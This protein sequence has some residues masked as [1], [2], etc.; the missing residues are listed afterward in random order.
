MFHAG[1]GSQLHIYGL[2]S[3][4]LLLQQTVLRGGTRLHGIEFMQQGNGGL[5]LLHG[6]RL[7]T[8]C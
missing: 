1:V 7:V 2:Q 3:G 6:G 8:V 4:H 5:L